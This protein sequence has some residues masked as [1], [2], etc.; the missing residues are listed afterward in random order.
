MR[1]ILNYVFLFNVVISINFLLF[2]EFF[3]L[4][5]FSLSLQEIAL[6]A[7]LPSFDYNFNLFYSK[8]IFE[9][10]QLFFIVNLISCTVIL[11][12]NIGERF[13]AIELI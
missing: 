11:V 10:F 6:T 1:S 3:S 13:F 7:L 4:P 8:N 12:E 9:P 5:F 2:I